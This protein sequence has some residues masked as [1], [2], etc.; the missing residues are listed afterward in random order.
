MTS[1][2]D[3]NAQLVHQLREMRFTQ[4]SIDAIEAYGVT[5]LSQLAFAVGQPGQAIQDQAVDAFLNGALG[6]A[7]AINESANIKRLAFEAQT[8]LVASLRQK[9][10]S[11]DDQPRKIATAERSSRM[12]RIRQ[13]LTGLSIS[14]EHEPSHG[15]LDKACGMFESNCL[16]YLEP[17]SCISR[18]LEV[19]GATKSRELTLE[20]G[21]L[22]LKAGD[23][24]LT[25]P[26]DSEIKVHYA[27]IRR[28]V[29]LEFAQLV[30]YE[31]HCQWE[32]WLFESL[33]R[34]T[35]P[36]FQHPS[37]AQVL[38]CDKAA[39]ARLGS[40]VENIRRQADGTFPLGEA[41]LALRADPNI[42]L[43]LSPC[44]RSSS[45]VSQSSTTR[46][47][48]YQQS[49][50][51]QPGG[52]KGKGKS[53]GRKGQKGSPPIPSEL[54]GKYH[55]TQNGEAI[56]FGFNCKSGCPEKSVKPG[57]RCSKGWHVC[58]EPRCQQNHSLQN[59]S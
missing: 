25:C 9:V 23:D 20:K 6:R 38:L 13:R 57:E 1:L 5:T 41:L 42:A 52:G 8:F 19:Q 55:K 44:A 21:S 53:K 35:P 10:D 29:A 16:K 47:H 31:Q 32:A 18:S 49:H 30:S 22:V 2:I 15:L 37:L 36:G 58:A 12:D 11:T 39:F 26:T 4:A 45:G 3:S 48:P 14:G 24:K 51:P 46:P 43:Y 34:E 17:A 7:P 33:H 40:T 28:A 50:P 54:R 27:M 56:C 59:H